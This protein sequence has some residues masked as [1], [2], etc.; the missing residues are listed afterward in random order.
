MTFSESKLQYQ[1]H[2]ESQLSLILAK[3][4]EVQISGNSPEALEAIVHT[5]NSQDYRAK[6]QAELTKELQ[7]P[8]GKIE[9]ITFLICVATAAIVTLTMFFQLFNSNQCKVSH[10]YNRYSISRV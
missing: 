1:Q 3:D 10:V 2:R 4:G 7:P 9:S 5:I 6:L 8:N